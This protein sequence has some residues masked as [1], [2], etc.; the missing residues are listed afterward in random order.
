V[1]QNT[2]NLVDPPD[3]VDSSQLPGGSPYDPWSSVELKYGAGTVLGIQLVTDTYPG[4]PGGSH[5]VVVDNTNI[6]G[7]LY[8]YEFT[9]KEDCKKGGYKDFTFAPG[10]FKNQGQCVSYFARQK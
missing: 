10:P 1:W 6:D 3:L 7:T 8:D 2:G 9:S 4:S 5:T